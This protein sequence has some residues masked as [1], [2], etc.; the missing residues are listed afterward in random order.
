MTV[1]CLP[2]PIPRQT[3]DVWSQFN[4]QIATHFAVS[5]GNEWLV[6]LLRDGSEVGVWQKGQNIIGPAGSIGL[7][8]EKLGLEFQEMWDIGEIPF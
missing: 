7:V 6:K 2:C 5:E 1:K 8:F 3:Y 4:F